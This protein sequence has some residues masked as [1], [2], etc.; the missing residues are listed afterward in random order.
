MLYSS[1][2]NAGHAVTKIGLPET[3]L[4]IIPG[5]GGTQRITRL[6]G[7]A[8]AKELIFT[9]RALT[10]TEAHKWG[11]FFSLCEEVWCVDHS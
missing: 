5:A 11:G 3:A 9:A 6:L 10:A 2:C 7:P 4:G 8:K 1:P